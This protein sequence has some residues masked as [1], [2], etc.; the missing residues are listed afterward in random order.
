MTNVIKLLNDTYLKGEIYSITGSKSN[1]NNICIKWANGLM[2]C[3]GHKSFDVDF[4]N[5]LGQMYRV[6]KYNAFT[7]PAEFTTFPTV[8]VN[9]QNSADYPFCFVYGVKRTATGIDRIDLMRPITGT[10]TVS[11]FYIAIGFW[12]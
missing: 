11:I 6:I 8:F 5:Q 7:F 1:N 4:Q 9:T 2:I 12:K 3:Y 10:G